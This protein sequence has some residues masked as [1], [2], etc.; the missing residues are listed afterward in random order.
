MDYYDL[1][2]RSDFSEG[3]SSIQEIAERAK[4]LGF[5]GICFAENFESLRQLEKLREKTSGISKKI[6][7]NIFLGFEA[8]N[9][10]ELK[11]LVSIRKK[12][13]IL[14]VNGSDLNLNRKAVETPEVDI[15]TNPEIGGKS[16]GF[17][18]V[19]AKLANKNNVAIEVNFREI[20]LSYKNTRSRVIKNI[21]KNVGLCKKF[22]APLITCS[23]AISHWQLKDPKV[24]VSMGCLLGLEIDEAK[25]SLSETPNKIIKMITERQ[26]KEWVRP[27]VKVVR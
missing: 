5:K 19:M 2:V 16:S 18:H 3:E 8:R 26:C 14:L 23:G 15:L 6:N 17:N 1:D 12:Y 7:I 24:L 9:K 21:T 20:L 22:K 10:Y 13:D 4:L 27:G 25:K 11:K